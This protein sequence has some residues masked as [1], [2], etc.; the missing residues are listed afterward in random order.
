VIG[1][2]VRVERARHEGRLV[3]SLDC[4]VVRPSG[5]LPRE[6]LLAIL[7]QQSFRDHALGYCNGTTVLHMNSRA[8]PAYEFVRP[9][10]D[11]ASAIAKR[12]APLLER[13][14]IA[15]DECLSLAALRDTLLPKLMSGELRVQ[16]AEHLLGDAV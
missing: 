13:S 16:H 10:D 5:A 8:I 2:A 3:A 6:V 11:V 7:S 1:R 9:S 12:M 4:V 15:R 14:E